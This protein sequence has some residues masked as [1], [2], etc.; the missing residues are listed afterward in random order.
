[1]QVT[2]ALVYLCRG[3]IGPYLEVLG[4]DELGHEFDVQIRSLLP[5]ADSGEKESF[6]SIREP[7]PGAIGANSA[8]SD[9][10]MAAL[11]DEAVDEAMLALPGFLSSETT[12]PATRR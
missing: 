5:E 4:G 6:I 10:L 3:F 1:M 8:L 7:D 12:E 2:T 11:A 9:W